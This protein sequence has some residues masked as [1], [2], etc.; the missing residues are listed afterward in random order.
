MAIYTRVRSWTDITVGGLPLPDLLVAVLLSAGAMVVVSRTPGAGTGLKVAGSVAVLAM[1]L[2]VAWARR[3]PVG[4]A[5]ALA[6]GSVLNAVLIGPMV[7]CGATLPA[8]FIV[9]FAVAARCRRAPAALGLVFCLVNVFAQTVSDPRLGISQFPLMLVVSCVFF[10]LGRVAR[11]HTAAVDTLRGRTAELRQQR[12]QTEAMTRR[13][14][15]ARITA[16]V[17]DALRRRLSRISATACESRRAL[18]GEPREAI[19][20]LEQ[21]ESEGREALQELRRIVGSLD[22]LP[23]TGP[24]PTLADLA[25]L[26]A[27]TTSADARLTVEGDERMLPAGME[28]TAY[29][30]TEHLVAALDD[31]PTVR[32]DVRLR[33]EP[34]TF[35]LEVSGPPARGVEVTAVL[36]AARERAAL[37]GGTLEERLGGGLCQATARLPL[38]AHGA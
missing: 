9:A 23:P 15:R 36:A 27:R 13:A 21:V 10:G 5:A 3:A 25:G 35:Q 12:E 17:D 26:L 38:V 6:A 2:P 29:R 28:L 33:F 31:A 4:A 30:I 8:A 1:T 37:Y 34:S 11:S 19:E 24:Q 22:P 20:L 7:R 32:I 16:D 18:A 14:N